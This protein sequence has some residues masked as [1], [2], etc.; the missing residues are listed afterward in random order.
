MFA[1]TDYLPDSWFKAKIHGE[2][3]VADIEFV[4]PPPNDGEHGVVEVYFTKPS[5]VVKLD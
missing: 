2:L 5:G 1:D 4:D 3:N